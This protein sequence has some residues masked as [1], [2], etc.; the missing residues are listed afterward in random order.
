L[1]TLF[2]TLGQACAGAS[3]PRDFLLAL[4]FALQP[5]LPH[6]HAELLVPDGSGDQCYRLGSHGLGPLWSDPG[7]VITAEQL[8]LRAL[9]GDAGLLLVR[10]ALSD[11]RGAWSI[12]WS[13]GEPGETPRSILGVR[14][15]IL[16]RT[17]GLLFLGSEG[18]DFFSETDLELFDHVGALIAP[19]VDSFSLLWH[20]QVLRSNL[21]VL[22]HI[23]M[24]LSKIAELLAVHP[25]LGEGTR[26]FAAQAA[27][28]LPVDRIE[29]A[30]RLGD[31]QRVA[32]VEPGDLTPLA[33]R[34]QQTLG[35]TMVGQVIRGEVAYL[36]TDEDVGKGPVSVLV[37]PLRVAGMILGA[38]AMTALPSA[39]FTRTD[40]AV[41]QQL[42]DLIAPH[43]EVQR[44]ATLSPPAFV[45]GWK[46]TPRF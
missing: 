16:E 42:G 10:D 39:A 33:D 38:L 5:L 2:A 13:H 22:R 37:V 1:V 32:I 28:L 12:P 45:P 31:E 25:L 27:A 30:I 8:D 46:R 20:Q 15:R 7:L 41:A 11:P 17:V 44:R 21:S 18:E 43:L 34:P 3:T 40:M 4:S 9:F 14:L 23:P 24:H 29:F 6:D 26:L 35:G 36:L 19:R